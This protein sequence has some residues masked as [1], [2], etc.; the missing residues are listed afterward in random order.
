[1]S[2]RWGA[3]LSD[4]N[5]PIPGAVTH[6]AARAAFAQVRRE[7][8][9]LTPA[10]LRREAARRIGTDYDTFLAAWKKAGKAAVRPDPLPTP[11]PG[12]FKTKKPALDP[13]PIQRFE[14]PKSITGNFDDE[15]AEL[16]RQYD[17]L[18][19]KIKAHG[20]TT[21]EHAQRQQFV[22][23]ADAIL[24]RKQA[25]L[26]KAD[27]RRALDLPPED[28]DR[29]RQ[30]GSIRTNASAERLDANEALRIRDKYVVNDDRTVARNRGLRSARPSAADKRWAAEVERLIRT[31]QVAQDAVVYRGAALTPEQIQNLIP[32]LRMVDK[33]IV[34]VAD[35][36][37]QAKFYVEE[38]QR[39]NFGTRRVMF[40]I[41]VPRGA[42]AVDVNVGEFVFQRN[43]TMLIRKVT[44][45]GDGSVHVVAE[46]I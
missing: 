1:M 27:S 36:I 39:V 12:L 38:R 25:A 26:R 6:E 21:A 29:W 9:T 23:D 19:A 31:Q 24:K 30:A 14:A 5:C 45:A 34:S 13:V 18:D 37:N 2:A 41:R 32:G 40:E 35:E 28:A 11:P 16:R 10:Q 17:V 44:E 33:G 15:V 46:M 3:A 4:I 43:T 22:T 20:G 42:T 8:P 7:M